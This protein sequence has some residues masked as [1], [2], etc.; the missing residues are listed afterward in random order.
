MYN[1][2]PVRPLIVLILPLCVLKF[3]RNFRQLN[4]ATILQAFEM[5][6]ERKQ[7]LDIHGCNI[8]PDAF[9]VDCHHNVLSHTCPSLAPN[10]FVCKCPFLW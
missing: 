7:M 9:N 8:N 3:L 4:A 5:S 1:P 6:S 2:P 10:R